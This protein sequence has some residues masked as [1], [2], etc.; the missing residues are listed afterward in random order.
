[1]VYKKNVHFVKKLKDFI[2]KEMFVFLNVAMEL[3]NKMNNVMME[4]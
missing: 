2:R 3:K 4:I 1:M